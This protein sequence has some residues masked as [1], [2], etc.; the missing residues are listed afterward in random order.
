MRFIDT[1]GQTN[2]KFVL[3]VVI[4]GI[5]VGEGALLYG[6]SKPE[7]EISQITSPQ[8]DETEDWQTYT[9]EKFGFE[10]K[11][12]VELVTFE[13]EE[14][15]Y[16]TWED[17]EAEAGFQDPI[18]V[19]SFEENP[20]HLTPQEYYDGNPGTDLFGSTEAKDIMTITIS[21]R[22]AMIF[23]PYISS[24]GGEVIVVSLDSRFLVINDDGRSIREAGLLDQILSTFRFVD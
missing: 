1:T 9:S 12:P 10:V 11:Y 23:N 2:W 18:L 4:L 21:G 3:I 13:S 15:F 24:A 8:D 19:F 6:L 7:G 20:Q 14:I 22:P 5:M 16:F 17:S